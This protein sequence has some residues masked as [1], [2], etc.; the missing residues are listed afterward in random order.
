MRWMFSG[1]GVAALA[2][3]LWFATK[4]SLRRDDPA[5]Y[6]HTRS[7][8]RAPVSAPLDLDDEYPRKPFDKQK[9]MARRLLQL[10][11][12]ALREQIEG[13]DDPVAMAFRIAVKGLA[14]DDINRHNDTKL[15]EFLISNPWIVSHDGSFDVLSGI[16]SPAGPAADFGMIS[17]LLN[18]LLEADP[19]KKWAPWRQRAMLQSFG[20]THGADAAKAGWLPPVEGDDFVAYVRGCAAGTT[21]R[22][23]VVAILSLA[24][25]KEGHDKAVRIAMSELLGAD[26]QATSRVLNALPPSRTKDLAVSEMVMW[27]AKVGSKEECAAWMQTIADPEVRTSTAERTSEP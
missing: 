26:A 8:F 7:P 4:S 15:L 9:R 12:A 22:E 20:A 3:V 14:E 24:E 6:E 16:K 5:K 1:I 18:T 23:E 17:R 25:S 11:P 21:K 19:D 2:A 10:S 27:L 13:M